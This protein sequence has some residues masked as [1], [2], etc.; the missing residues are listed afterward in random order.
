MKRVASFPGKLGVIGI[1]RREVNRLLAFT[2]FRIATWNGS[3]YLADGCLHQ[4]ADAIAKRSCLLA[5]LQS[6]VAAGGWIYA[7]GLGAAML[8][9]E[10][11]L[12]NQ[13]RIPWQACCRGATAYMKRLNHARCRKCKSTEITGS[14][15]AARVYADMKAVLG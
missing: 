2:Q 5:S 3:I 15:K 14:P 9:Q 13:R 4:F 10:V 6:H 11:V 7:E 1:A 8:G 12:P